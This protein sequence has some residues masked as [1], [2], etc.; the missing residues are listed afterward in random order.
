MKK[1]K[2]ASNTLIKNINKS[3]VFD[4]IKLNRL[5]SRAQIAKE[6]GLNKATVSK[7]VSELI[8]ESLVKEEG[9]GASS[10]GR[11]P[12]MLYFNKRAGFSVG[13]DLGVNYINGLLTD[14][15]GEILKET[16]VTIHSTEVNYVFKI[17]INIIEYLINN[18]PISPYGIVGI[19]I[20]VPG[21]VSREG[22]IV[23][24]PN[25]NWS[26][27]QIGEKLENLFHIPVKVINEA[28]A[29]AHS[30][31]IL[32]AGKNINDQVYISIGIGIGSGIIINQQL[33]EGTFGASGEMGH[34]SIDVNGK[35][36]SCGNR[37]CWELYASEKAL[38]SSAFDWGLTTNEGELDIDYLLNEAKKNN[39]TVVHI[40]EKLGENIGF[41]LVNI[42]NMLD[43][44]VIIIGNRISKFEYW[45]SE[46][47]QK[48]LSERIPNYNPFQTTIRFSCLE[49]DAIALGM[50]L[51]AITNFFKEKQLD[52]ANLK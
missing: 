25:L 34:F 24:A 36:C 8:E 37:G 15:N 45:I 1:I 32:G 42:I 28:N 4:A 27:V 3:I 26:N 39:P 46:S 48:V 41:G 44:N 35:K 40:L 16:R 52:L 9:E 18:A 5:I 31:H 30:E 33:Y 13:I 49:D 14:L 20:G 50:N 38:I 21:K 2:I 23:F 19:G 17:I 22:N 47:I 7:L 11:K 43:P 6:N 51:F 12:V 29:G 10:G